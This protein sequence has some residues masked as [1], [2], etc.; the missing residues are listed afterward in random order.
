M[1]APLLEMDPFLSPAM[2]SK[3]LADDQ[4][5]RMA[6][7]DE[8]HAALR[9]NAQEVLGIS[10]LSMAGMARDQAWQLMGGERRRIPAFGPR[11]MTP[12]YKPPS[13]PPL[14]DLRHRGQALVSYPVTHQQW[15][16]RPCDAP[17]PMDK[18]VSYGNS[19]SLPQWDPAEMTATR[20][21]SQL[22]RSVSRAGFT[23]SR[24]ATAESLARPPDVHMVRR[25]L[26]S[27]ATQYDRLGAS[28]DPMTVR[29]MK[30]RAGAA[31]DEDAEEVRRV[32]QLADQPK[33][34][35]DW[36]MGSASRAL[37]LAS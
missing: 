12:L 35:A 24:V 25:M 13:A 9:L 30:G 28:L 16:V 7:H 26:R 20:S 37:V 8:R 34:L 14:P 33:R 22:R 15:L 17:R 32:L 3:H 36:S 18:V 10:Q 19:S 5:R 29:P 31:A 27:P 1:R 23:L 21:A 11:S 4:R 2:A 6:Q